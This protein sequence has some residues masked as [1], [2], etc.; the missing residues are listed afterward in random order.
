MVV[1]SLPSGYDDTRHVQAG[2][3]DCHITVG[4]DRAR[5]RIPRFLIQ[6]H[7]Q[8]DTA[9]VR[10]EAIARMDH[11]ETSTHGHDVYQE[12]LHV[13]LAR[14]SGATVH[15]QV[16]HGPLPSN[17]GG[18]ISAAV[19]Y[20]RQEA[21][22]AVDVYEGDRSPG[23]PPRFSP[24]GGGRPPTLKPSATLRGGMS[25]ESPAEDALTPEELD[26]VLADATGSTPEQIRAGAED[27]E[28]AP[29]A[30]ADVVDE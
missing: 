27:L 20:L 22:Y 3:P 29:L 9:P 6:L 4:F 18:L 26:E 8:A 11:N 7:Y 2:R 15:L 1:P 25:H 19:R 24:D 16:R 28:L 5:R 12:G 30:E 10:W 17:R 21:Q 14:R 13:D 23:R